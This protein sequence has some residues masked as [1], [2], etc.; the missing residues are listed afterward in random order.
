M[1]SPTMRSRIW[2]VLTPDVA[3]GDA[4]ADQSA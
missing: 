3:A 4:K 2:I 1:N